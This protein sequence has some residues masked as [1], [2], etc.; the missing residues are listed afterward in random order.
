MAKID[1]YFISLTN[2]KLFD[3]EIAIQIN[4]NFNNKIRLDINNYMLEKITA[5]QK[6]RKKS[7]DLKQ[8]FFK[9]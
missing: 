6:C 3:L 8:T 9:G 5:K 4:K 1:R 2:D 7:K